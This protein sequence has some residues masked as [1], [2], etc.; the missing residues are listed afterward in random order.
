MYNFAPNFRCILNKVEKKSDR[1]LPQ[2]VSCPLG[3]VG[4]VVPYLLFAGRATIALKGKYKLNFH[5]ARHLMKET[6]N[7]PKICAVAG[8]SFAAM[9]IAY[10]ANSSSIEESKYYAALRSQVKEK[11][12]A[13]LKK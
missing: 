13:L 12:V 1:I 5:L 6:I 11:T 2:G 4:T 3:F 9:P 8:S 10:C 7:L